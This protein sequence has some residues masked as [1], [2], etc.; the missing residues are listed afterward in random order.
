M[1]I[2][3]QLTKEERCSEQVY[4]HTGFGRFHQCERRAVVEREGKPYCKIHDPEYVKKKK[5]A[6]QAKYDKKWASRRVELCEHILL[7]ACKEALEASHNPVIER[8]L[9]KAIAEAEGKEQGL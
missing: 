8:I 1:A 2:R 7:R 6:S 5:L 3:K 4:E 9:S